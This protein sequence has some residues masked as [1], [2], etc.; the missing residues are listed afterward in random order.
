MYSTGMPVRSNFVVTV[1]VSPTTGLVF[2]TVLV[3]R[4]LPSSQVIAAG[5][6]TAEPGNAVIASPAAAANTAARCTLLSTIMCLQLRAGRPRRR[7]GAD[8][9]EW[10]A[11]DHAMV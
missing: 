10:R 7:R 2:D 11:V 1:I 4:L 6:A 8:S 5:A 3:R 9:P